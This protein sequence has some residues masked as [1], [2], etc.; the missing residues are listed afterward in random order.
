[1]ES[2][3]EVKSSRLG[4]KFQ[5]I[6]NDIEDEMVDIETGELIKI[7]GTEKLTDGATIETPEIMEEMGEEHNEE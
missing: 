3:S 5:S 4:I 7:A 2:V 6:T 1:M